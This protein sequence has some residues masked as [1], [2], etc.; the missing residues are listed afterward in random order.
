[1]LLPGVPVGAPEAQPLPLAEGAAD[2]ELALAVKEEEGAAL[3]ERI[4]LTLAATELEG[5]CEGLRDPLAQGV[6]E[7]EP[8]PD[9]QALAA[10]EAVVEREGEGVADTDFARLALSCGEAELEGQGEGEAEVRALVVEE[11]QA[12]SVKDGDAEGA[13]LGLAAPLGDALVGVAPKILA[14]TAAVAEPPS[15]AVGLTEADTHRDTL[16]EGL[17]E[18]VREGEPVEEGHAESVKD[19]DAEG[20][21]LGLAAPLGDALVGVAPKILAVTA[22]V[23]VPPRAAEGLPDME[24]LPLGPEEREALG[25]PVPPPVPV[26]LFCDPEGEPLA[27]LL[28]M[29]GALAGAARV[30]FAE[31]LGVA[32][33]WP[34]A[35]VQG[36]TLPLR[37]SEGLPVPLGDAEGERN[38]EA[39]ALCVRDTELQ[40]DDVPEREGEP[41][42]P[43][44]AVPLFDTLCVRLAA[45]VGAAEGVL[46]P[47]G[48]LAKEAVELMELLAEPLAT[49]EKVPL[50]LAEGVPLRALEALREREGDAV[51]LLLVV[52]VVE[53][54]GD[55]VPLSVPELQPDV[56]ALGDTDRER[57]GEPEKLLEAVP[58]GE[59][60]GDTVP[61]RD[62]VGLPESEGDAV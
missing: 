40:G 8:L 57:E 29:G 47:D 51:K 43:P 53:L 19:G 35:V 56:E 42:L 20:A 9:A 12:D 45:A 3:P 6:V 2:P 50:T 54:E 1:M 14:V 61:L 34:E 41:D 30:P 60:E 49:R 38:E 52:P 26:G 13:P 59:S 25:E 22:A 36:D 11:G 5:D 16:G 28:F 10:E 15:T 39:Q 37:D 7:R 18:A 4:K 55:R 33:A 62:R 27:A 24:A 21:P 17:G 44:L 48:E 31:T 58:Q 32:V 46:L 23:V